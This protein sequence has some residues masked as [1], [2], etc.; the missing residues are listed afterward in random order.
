ML[1]E[2]RTICAED[3][4]DNRINTAFFM[5]N[6]NF[7]EDE[8]LAQ[9]LQDLYLDKIEKIIE[10]NPGV[11]YKILANE[12]QEKY[13]K[14]F[15][16]DAKMIKEDHEIYAQM[17]LYYRMADELI[18][19]NPGVCHQILAKKLQEKCKKI[20]KYNDEELNEY[21]KKYHLYFPEDDEKVIGSISPAM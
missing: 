14:V 18:A 19:K 8:D 6:F 4:K 15:H 17:D 10:E 7:D 12:L 20:F 16:Y 3:L 9:D 1:N 11:C 5:P 21:H 2:I 13:R